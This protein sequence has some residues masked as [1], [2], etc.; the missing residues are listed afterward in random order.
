MLNIIWRNGDMRGI[1][2]KDKFDAVINMWSS[3]GYFDEAGDRAFVKAVSRSLK[4]GGSFLIDTQLMETLL[5]R[6]QDHEK[7]RVGDVLMSVERFFDHATCRNNETFTFVRKGRQ[8]KYRSSIRLYA[9]K[10]LI[11][12]LK[13]NGFK[14]SKAY[15]SLSKQEFKLGAK[16]L[17][18]IAQK[19]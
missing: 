3:F 14:G 12:L 6:Y 5:P 16:R 7:H 15:G 19:D 1:P 11:E 18:L 8:T 4:K 10:E 2:W 13:K 17:L 9:H